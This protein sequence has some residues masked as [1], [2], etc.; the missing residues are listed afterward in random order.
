MSLTYWEITFFKAS[1]SQWWKLNCQSEKI[2]KVTVQEIQYLWRPHHCNCKCKCRK[3][4]HKLSYMCSEFV[5]TRVR[6]TYP[7]W[8]CSWIYCAF[9]QVLTTPNTL[10]PFLAQELF[11]FASGMPTMIIFF[12]IL[13]I[14]FTTHN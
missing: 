8:V 6:P 14:L 7:H 4:E 13:Y 3:V 1:A 5:F 11:F 10:M 2:P 9:A 12:Y